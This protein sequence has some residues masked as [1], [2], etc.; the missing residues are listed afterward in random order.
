MASARM[1]PSTTA[2]GAGALGGAV[3]VVAS[4]PFLGRYGWD[5][6]ELYFLSASRHLSLG[7]VDFPPVTAWVAWLVRTLAG[8]SLQA[9]RLVSLGC[10]VATVFFVALIARELGGGFR[11]QVGAALAWA[12]TPLIVGSATIFHPTWF[13][14]LGWAAFLYV[15]TRIIVRPEPRLW[16]LLGVVA[17]LGL[18][19]KYTIAFLL[20]AFAAALVVGARDMLRTRG[21]WVGA[22]IAILLLV[23]N[24][25][26]QVAHGWPSVHFA[27][28]QS[29]KASSDTSRPLF[30]A[31]QL[32][33]LGATFVVAVVG[34]VWL[35]RRRLRA[36]AI[37]PA[38]VTALF[39]VELGRG[40]YPL[41]A[42]GLAVAAGAVALEAWASRWRL[43]V[44]S[45]LV[46]CQVATLF[47]VAP[48]IWPVYSTRAMIDR[49]I[50]KQSFYKD[51]IGWPELTAS[52]VRIWETLPPAERANGAI[53]A[54]NYGEASAL[55]LYGHGKL[56]LVLSGH[57]S[58]QYW[59]PASLPQR[60]LV[61]VGIDTP[62]TICSTWHIAAR[63]DNR[64]HIANE[65]QGRTIATCTL[66][67]PLGDLWPLIA[68][69][70][71]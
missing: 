23:P 1:T 61:I 16:P 14:E 43:F 51:E 69:N 41:P 5:R 66:R 18:E 44:L 55:E 46:A 48:V 21:P 68:R 20:V 52:V 9:L 67:E 59:R 53:L 57:L 22:G 35:W 70:T 31:E 65:E 56:P 62:S 47:V 54:G 32:L 6:D 8:D 12:L 39:F 49:G 37:V 17:G 4:V 45:L 15:A 71:L 60:H 42:D 11:A 19:A 64:W 25:A 7:Y 13:D 30:I 58:W 26:W 36:L 40:Y 3:V 29:A 27:A 50:W 33:F 34:V 63:I 24:L 28:S 38:L 2:L 10:G